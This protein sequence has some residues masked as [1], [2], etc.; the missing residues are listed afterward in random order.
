MRETIVAGLAVLAAAC[1]PGA[2]VP[3]R[4]DVAQL[5]GEWVGD[6]QSTESGRSGSITFTLEAGQDTA[7]GD[8]LMTVAG[9]QN[10][11][12][13]RVDEVRDPPRTQP[14][15]IEFVQVRRGVVS[16]RLEQYRDPACGCLV[17][18]VFSGSL[19]GDTLSGSYRTYHQEGQRIVNGVWRVTRTSG[20]EG[21][22]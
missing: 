5:A 16:G 22:E 15:R 17:S 9:A 19:K 2:P 10:P 21:R 3:V 11:M 12:A 6:Y 1:G 14:L 13:N 7:R 8:V 20:G 4:G 18:T